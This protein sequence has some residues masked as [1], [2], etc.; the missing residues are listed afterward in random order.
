ME[1]SRPI[2]ENYLLRAIVA[3][4]KMPGSIAQRIPTAYFGWRCPHHLSAKK[5]PFIYCIT[6]IPSCNSY[7]AYCQTTHCIHLI[8]YACVFQVRR[9]WHFQ[10]STCYI[11]CTRYYIQMSAWN[12]Q[13][14]ELRWPMCLRRWLI[15]IL[16]KRSTDISIIG[17]PTI[18]GLTYN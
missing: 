11:P 6:H 2:F 17:R 1:S 18:G 14:A 7:N 9:R 5:V 12:F 13:A 10:N 15:I 8:Q 4:V 16:I 3:N